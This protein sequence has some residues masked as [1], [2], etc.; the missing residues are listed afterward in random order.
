MADHPEGLDLGREQ[1]L[2]LVCSTQVGFALEC[3]PDK[4]P[5]AGAGSLEAS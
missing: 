1:A 4:D 5:I 3:H 2:L